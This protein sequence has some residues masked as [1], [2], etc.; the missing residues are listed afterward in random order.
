MPMRPEAPWTA[1][2]TGESEFIWDVPAAIDAGDY[3]Q[4]PAGMDQ[5]PMRPKKSL[6]LSSQEFERGE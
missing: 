1:M 2:R 4:S 5:A 6:T 3:G